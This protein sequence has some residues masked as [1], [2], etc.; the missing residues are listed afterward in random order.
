M[1]LRPP[2]FLRGLSPVETVL[3]ESSDLRVRIGWLTVSPDA[4]SSVRLSVKNRGSK[5][6][7]PDSG[8]GLILGDLSGKRT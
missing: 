4:R 5:I 7:C 6:A 2:F 3:D 1:K 8:S